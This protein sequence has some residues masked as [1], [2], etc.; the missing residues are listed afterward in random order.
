MSWTDNNCSIE[1]MKKYKVTITA[2]V[3]KGVVVEANSED[4]AR[5]AAHE[6]FT[7]AHDG[8]VEKYFED[9]DSVEIVETNYHPDD[10]MTCLFRNLTPQEEKAFFQHAR[11]NDPDMSKWNIFHPACRKVWRERGFAP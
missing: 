1:E 5:D 7:A 3:T 4:E 2:R 9:V 11:D 8:T 10:V 6:Q